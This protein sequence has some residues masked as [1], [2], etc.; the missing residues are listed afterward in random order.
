MTGTPPETVAA[1]PGDYR[2]IE[3]VAEIVVSGPVFEQVAEDV[4]P[5]GLARYLA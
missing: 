2:V 4:Q 3:C 1:S 5:I